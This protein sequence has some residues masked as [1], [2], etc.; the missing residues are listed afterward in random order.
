ME[1]YFSTWKLKPN[2][3]KTIVTPFHLNN[4]EARKEVDV[5]FAGSRLQNES[6]PKYL[7]ITLDRTLTFKKHLESLR[8]KA[9]SRVNI[10]HKLAGTTW[11]CDAKTLKTAGIGLVY[12]VAEYCAPVWFQSSHTNLID[13]QLNETMR[14]IS[15]T[16]KPTPV[17]WLCVLS[18]IAPP[19]LRREQAFQNEVRKV[20]SN[21]NLPIH[22]D[23]DDP[24]PN[25]LKSRRPYWIA[26]AESMDCRIEDKWRDLWTASLVRNQNLVPDPTKEQP[27]FALTRKIWCTLNRIRCDVGCTA[28]N[29]H[30]WGW[31]DSPSCTC[32]MTQT[33]DHLIDECPTYA[34]KG[35]LQDL[36]VLTDDAVQWLRSLEVK[37]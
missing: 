33:I 14:V 12:S 4:R 31:M 13:T 22:Q 18:N 36:H 19:H 11:G 15:G 8:Q 32:G 21:P 7:G 10:L 34:F 17:P 25:R 26:S 20:L 9:K 23:V 1:E 24:P 29:L 2:P 6:N 28:S 5:F 3:Q 27:G 35:G 30:K 37:L 16:L